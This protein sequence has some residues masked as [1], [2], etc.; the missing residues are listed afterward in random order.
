MIAITDITKNTYHL[1]FGTDADYDW[2]SVTKILVLSNNLKSDFESQKLV[3]KGETEEKLKY[4][5]DLFFMEFAELEKDILV[6]A[7]LLSKIKIHPLFIENKKFINQLPKTTTALGRNLLIDTLIE[8]N[9]ADEI[10]SDE[11]IE[12]IFK[13]KS[14]EELREQFENWSEVN[15]DKYTKKF[16]TFSILKYLMVASLVGV[17]FTFSYNTI[18]NNSY[19]FDNNPLVYTTSKIIIKDAGLGFGKEKKQTSISVQ[20]LN[21]NDAIAT[22]KANQLLPNTFIFNKNNL[23]LVLAENPDNFELLQVNENDFFIKMNGKFYKL[24]LT[25]EFKKLKEINDSLIIEKLEQIL[26]ENE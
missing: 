16:K 9:N 18:F 13:K 23:R 3:D 26:F 17:I 7:N 25:K 21:Y 8:S 14:R 20:I 5:Q 2:L 24:Q 19:D 6:D 4:W 15:K 12:N 11:I 10:I 22:G 1:T